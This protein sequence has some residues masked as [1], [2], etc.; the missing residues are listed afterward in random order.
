MS[1]LV[2]CEAPSISSFFGKKNKLI[3]LQHF[4]TIVNRKVVILSQYLGVL[5]NK[6]FSHWKTNN[7]TPADEPPPIRSLRVGSSTPPFCLTHS[8]RRR[9]IGVQPISSNVAVS[10]KYIG[11]RDKAFLFQTCVPRP[12]RHGHSVFMISLTNI[13]EETY[14]PSNKPPS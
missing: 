11:S 8:H 7:L 14:R 4:L 5:I 9:R 2:S 13:A 3:K 6:V 10:A 12:H 1:T